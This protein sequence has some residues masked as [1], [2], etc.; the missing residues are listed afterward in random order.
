MEVEL[1]E[2]GPP[3]LRQ[4]VGVRTCSAFEPP[5]AVVCED[6]CLDVAFERRW[7]AAVTRA[8]R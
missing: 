4:A 6:R 1:E 2:N 7:A 5:T 3:G 8:G